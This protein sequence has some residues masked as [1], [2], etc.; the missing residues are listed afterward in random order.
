MESSI[1]LY[2]NDNG[3]VNIQVHYEEVLFGSHK[4][5]WLSYSM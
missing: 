3:D 4:S 5:A 1:I 2:T